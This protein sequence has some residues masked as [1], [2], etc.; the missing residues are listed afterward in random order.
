MEQTVATPAPQPQLDHAAVRIIV[1]GTM[2][3]MFLAALDQTIVAPALPT[4]GRELLH[5]DQLSWVVTAYLLTA[6]AATPLYGKLSDVFGRRAMLL[7]AISVF[8]IG[9][10]LCALAPTMLVLIVARAVQ[11]L[12]GGGLISLAQTIIGDIVPPRER[13]RYQAYFTTVF[14]SASILGPLLGGFLSEALH[15][16]AIFWIN[17]PIGLLGFLMTNRVLKRLP[18]HDRPHR[19][20]IPGALLMVAATVALLSALTLGGERYAWTSPQVLGLVA[21]SALL[22]V[23]FGW[24]LARASEPFF[25]LDLLR[26]QVVRYA[27]AGSFFGIG[28]LLGLTIIMPVFFEG[29]IGLSTS[30]SGAALIAL[31]IGTVVGA[32]VAAQIL[33][34]IDHYKWPIIAVLSTTVPLTLILVA[35]PVQLSLFWIEAL[36][37]LI[38]VG[39][40]QIYPF[41]TVTL[42]NAVP[43]WQLGT[44][45]G[46]L[47]FVRSLGGAILIA[48]F[49]AI[50][51]SLGGGSGIDLAHT[52]AEALA[53]A[54]R[55]V[56]VA[57]ALAFALTTFWFGAMKELPLRGRHPTSEPSAATDQTISR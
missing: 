7:L 19:V 18:R 13:G 10:V 35:W 49:G 3:A 33:M 26:N 24:R 53:P 15:W 47:N 25:P 30:Q 43:M 56:F 6:T 48:G 29:V 1:I 4:I 14:M 52:D 27:V 50:F 23:L 57:A 12:G 45:T 22:W 54:F 16:S 2:V 38:G 36:L 20:D 32:N 11:G 44:A 21:A 41:A 40:G 17:V 39:I 5:L 31:M 8:L 46:A 34:R 28:T 51:L 42:Q 55:G 37:F 9:S